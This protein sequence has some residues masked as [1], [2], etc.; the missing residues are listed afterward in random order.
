MY[1]IET[2][3]IS[4]ATCHLKT[5]QRRVESHSRNLLNGY[6]LLQENEFKL[7]HNHNITSQT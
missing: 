5:K 1:Y 3:V 2:Y 6:N 4:I 7:F